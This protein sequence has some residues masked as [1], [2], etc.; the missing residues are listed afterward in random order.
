V[1]ERIAPRYSPEDLGQWMPAFSVERARLLANGM[2]EYLFRL[3][4]VGESPE[5]AHGG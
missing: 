1:A 5:A 3:R 2:Q 4:Q